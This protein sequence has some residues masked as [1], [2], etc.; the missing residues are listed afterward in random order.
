MPLKVK[1]MELMQKRIIFAALLWNYSTLMGKFHTFNEW[2]LS[3]VN[4]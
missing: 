1:V 3:S 4:H 2:Q